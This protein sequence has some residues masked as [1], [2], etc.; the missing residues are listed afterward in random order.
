M[1]NNIMLSHFLLLIEEYR[2]ITQEKNQFLDKILFIFSQT[3]NLKAESVVNL[4]K[5]RKNFSP[6]S[7]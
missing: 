3:S 1:K 6:C 7:L 2:L 5:N 4:L